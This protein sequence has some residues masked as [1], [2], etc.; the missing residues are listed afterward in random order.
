MTD[1]RTANTTDHDGSSASA[2]SSTT[3][4][5][6][7]RFNRQLFQRWDPI[8][9][10]RMRAVLGD[11]IED[12]AD[13]YGAD[14]YIR[15]AQCRF[16]YLEIQVVSAWKHTDYPY[17]QIAVFA[18]KG[19]YA[20]NAVLFFSLNRNLTFGYLFDLRDEDKEHP[21]HMYPGSSE[22]MYVVPRDRCHLIYLHTTDAQILGKLYPKS[23]DTVTAPPATQT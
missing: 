8:S 23:T 9:R 21:V 4:G 13:T 20:S 3:V 16:A 7:K 2:S 18:R 14:F 22:M 17:E 1:N 12:N 10:A 6:H 11:S 19:R 15:D 5:H